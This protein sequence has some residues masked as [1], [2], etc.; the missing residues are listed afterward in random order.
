M[1]YEDVA[2]AYD[3]YA[4][5]LWKNSE[6]SSESVSSIA[7]SGCTMNLRTFQN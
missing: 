2:K 4:A 1:S 3:R 7:F 6:K 5:I